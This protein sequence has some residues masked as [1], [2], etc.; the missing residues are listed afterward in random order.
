VQERGV[1]HLHIPIASSVPLDVVDVQAL[2]LAAGFGCV[3][4]LA[5]L[6][7]GAD[8]SNLAGYV[9]KSVAGYI[10]KSCEQREQ[11]PWRADVA[12]VETGELRK[13]HTTATYRGHSQSRGWGCTLKEI[14]A[15]HRDQARARAAALAALVLEPVAAQA[16]PDTSPPSDTG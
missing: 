3:I 16:I 11:L 14:R 12:D 13:M 7:A 9:S 2:A 15:V 10:T 1:I 8:F 6:P 4:D 5:P